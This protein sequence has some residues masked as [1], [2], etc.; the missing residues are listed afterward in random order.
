M[1]LR[2]PGNNHGAWSGAPASPSSTPGPADATAQPPGLSSQDWPSRGAGGPWCPER[3]GRPGRRAPGTRPSFEAEMLV[4]WAWG[5]GRR[6]GGPGAWPGHTGQGPVQGRAGHQHQQDARGCRWSAA[7]SPPPPT[8]PQRQGPGGDAQ[9]WCICSPKAWGVFVTEP[10]QLP[11]AV[12]YMEGLV[13]VRGWASLCA[14]LPLGW[15][16]CSLRVARA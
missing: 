14:C 6:A 3:E 2:P 4:R 5:L 15:R 12:S 10:G 16:V 11:G 9:V 13:R 1:G 7:L 8:V